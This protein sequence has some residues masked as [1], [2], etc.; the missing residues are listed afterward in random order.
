MK[1]V[2]MHAVPAVPWGD[3]CT[4]WPLVEGADLSVKLEV[5]PPGAAEVRHRHAAARQ[6]FYVLSGALQMVL[7]AETIDVRAGQGL[8]V[9]PGRVHQA[10]NPGAE[11]VQFL[12]VSSPTTRQ[13]RQEMP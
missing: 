3:G 7:E 13:D 10:R 11:A 8:E 2:D 4:A 1:A 6:F 9:P 12:V 5:M